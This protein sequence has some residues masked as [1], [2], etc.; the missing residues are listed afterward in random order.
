M[1]ARGAGIKAENLKRAVD[2]GIP[3]VMGTD[4]GNP[5]TLVGVAAYA[6]MEAMQAAGMT[7]TQV[8][9][10]ST[11][12]GARALRRPDLGTI[13]EGRIA[14]LLVI[15][16]DP[17]EDIANMRQPETVIRAGHVHGQTSL[18]AAGQVLLRASGERRSVA[19]N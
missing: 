16:A 13:E 14:D 10:A 19:S 6:E 18:R 2:A 3:V 15:R 1:D 5:L 11:R 12:N 4:V 17:T 8:L 7:P 9:I